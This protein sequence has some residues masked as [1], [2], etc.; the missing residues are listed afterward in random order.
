MDMGYLGFNFKINKSE[1]TCKLSAFFGQLVILFSKE[2]VVTIEAE[3]T[4]VVVGV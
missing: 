4:S 2:N 3:N 1:V